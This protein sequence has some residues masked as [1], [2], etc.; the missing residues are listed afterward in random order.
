MTGPEIKHARRRARLPL[1]LNPRTCSKNHDAEDPDNLLFVG[2]TDKG[3]EV[4]LNKRAA[5]SDLLVYVNINLVAL[6]GGHKSVAV[7]LA[8]Y[9]SVRHH[10][11][12]DTL[13]RSNSYMDPREGTRRSTTRAAGW[14]RSW[15]TPGSACSR[16]RPP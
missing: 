16:S 2:S 14:A 3:E 12:V 5:E 11:N 15:R 10:H 7:G 8:S 1:L 4:E 13:L 9:K 6:D